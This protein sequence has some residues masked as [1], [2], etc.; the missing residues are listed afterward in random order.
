MWSRSKINAFGCF[1]PVYCRIA[2][3]CQPVTFFDKMDM[4]AIECE[5][6]S[7]FAHRQHWFHVERSKV[8]TP[9]FINQIFEVEYYR[10]FALGQTGTDHQ[11]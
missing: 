11:I 6:H 1:A 4:S 3:K 10:V 7:P 8:K 2:H 9:V 5:K